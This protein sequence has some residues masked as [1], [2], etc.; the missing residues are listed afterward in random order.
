MFLY[1]ITAR[2]VSECGNDAGKAASS[3][4]P[5][6]QL[7]ATTPAVPSGDDLGLQGTLDDVWG[8]FRLSKLGR[9]EL[10]SASG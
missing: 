1:L 6:L 8:H 3:W 7:L 5:Q 2:S 4:A 9:R 10:L